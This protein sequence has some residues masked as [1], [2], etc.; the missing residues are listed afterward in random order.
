MT[1]AAKSITFLPGRSE[2]G[3]DAPTAR[4]A[5]LVDDGKEAQPNDGYSEAGQTV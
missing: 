1:L 3:G 2:D 4:L 5:L